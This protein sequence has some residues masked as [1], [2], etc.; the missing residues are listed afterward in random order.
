MTVDG[1]PGARIVDLHVVALDGASAR[2]VPVRVR[3]EAGEGGS[4][5]VAFIVTAVDDP[6]VSVREEAAFIVPR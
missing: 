1:M 5:R 3:A 2:A 6:S 4:H